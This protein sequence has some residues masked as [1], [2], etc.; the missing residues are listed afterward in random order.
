VGRDEVEDDANPALA[1]FGDEP[2]E[3]VER[4]QVGVDAAV[5]GDV[6]APVDVRA[7]EGRARPDRVDAEP[8]EVV[9]F[10]GEAWEIAHAVAVRVREGARIDLV[11][12]ATHREAS[13]RGGREPCA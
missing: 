4:A 11:D 10:R 3:V 9:E 7:G 1:R 13:Y 6:V 2:V 8:G 5:V 12:E